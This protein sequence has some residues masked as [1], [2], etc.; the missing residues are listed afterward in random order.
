MTVTLKCDLIE[1]NGFQIHNQH[2]K[3]TQKSLILLTNGIKLDWYSGAG[4][5]VKLSERRVSD[6]WTGHNFFFVLAMGTIFHRYALN[7]TYIESS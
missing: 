6:V 7:N 1:K 4:F 2:Q 5:I 3:L